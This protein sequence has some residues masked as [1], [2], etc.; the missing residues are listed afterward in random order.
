MATRGRQTGYRRMLAGRQRR[1]RV[2][3]REA[4]SAAGVSTITV[5]NM[6]EDFCAR[7]GTNTL[8]PGT[9]VGGIKVDLR[10]RAV[11][12]NGL[13]NSTAFAFGI[14]VIDDVPLTNEDVPGPIEQQHADWMYYQPLL[15]QFGV[16]ATEATV[17]LG[18]GS[19]AG[20]ESVTVRSMRKI[21][22]VGQSLVWAVESNNADDLFDI[23]VWTSTLLILA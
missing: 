19:V 15:P 14:L 21:E 10:L 22:E 20:G 12:E 4:H 7:Y 6:C 5:K 8:P 2:W 3:A 1:K 16:G 11:N 17:W 23:S 13:S 18:G 9:T